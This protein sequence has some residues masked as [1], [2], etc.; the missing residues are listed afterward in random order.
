MACRDAARRLEDFISVNPAGDGGRW[1]WSAQATAG[2]FEP[3][4]SR[5]EGFETLPSTDVSGGP[6]LW[7][8]RERAAC[9]SSAR[10][11]ASFLRASSP[12]GRAR[13]ARPP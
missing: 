13:R 10:S 2:S 1:L 6:R 9:V 12:R 11:S 3:F 8:R 7:M 5:I 4:D